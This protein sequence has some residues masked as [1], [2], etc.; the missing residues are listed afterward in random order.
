MKYKSYSIKSYCYLFCVACFVVPTIT[1]AAIHSDKVTPVRLGVWTTS[2]SDSN[3][4][5]GDK[6]SLR[7]SSVHPWENCA[8]NSVWFHGNTL[9][10][11][12]IISILLTA[13]T[14]GSQVLITVRDDTKVGGVVCEMT[15]IES[16]Y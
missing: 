6:V 10:G 3:W 8:Y 2:S 12:N 15:A 4:N 9:Q 7:L 5:S 16:P 1:S 11:K 14:T 13:I